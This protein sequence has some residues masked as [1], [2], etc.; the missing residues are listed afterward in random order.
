M[1]NLNWLSL[2]YTF[3]LSIVLLSTLISSLELSFV[4]THYFNFIYP[5]IDK[6]HNNKRKWILIH[7]I[8]I[9]C[10]LLSAILFF[11][12]KII[13]FKVLFLSLTLITLFSYINRTSSKDGAD[14]LRM[15]TLLTFSLCFLLDNSIGKLVTLVFLGLQVLLGYTTSGIAKLTSPYWRKGNVLHL[16]FGT[17]SYGVPKISNTLKK[18]PKLERL[19]SHSAIFIMLAVPI[20]F[21]IPNPIVLYIALFSIFSFHFATAIIMGLNDFLFT[22]PLAYPGIILLHEIFHNYINL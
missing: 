5:K 15:I 19:L 9:A 16:I 13:A 10:T 18:R 22:F 6:V 2:G 7:V 20:S 17:Y 14:Q 3:S 21:F 12:G 11:T 4:P 1:E 8:Q